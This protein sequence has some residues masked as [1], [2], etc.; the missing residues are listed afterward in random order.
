VSSSEKTERVELVVLESRGKGGAEVL[1]RPPA[2]DH[3]YVLAYDE[4]ESHRRF[5]RRVLRRTRQA[6]RGKR[7]L[8]KITCVL[9]DRAPIAV[10]TRLLRGLLAALSQQG[11]CR[12][13]GSDEQSSGV[14]ECMA[15]LTPSLRPGAGLEVRLFSPGVT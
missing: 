2:G 15:A 4:T 5:A 9:G 11:V 14:F 3:N 7:E 6:L 1:K 12:L 8:T 10:R 13:L